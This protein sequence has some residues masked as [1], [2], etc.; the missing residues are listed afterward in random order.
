MKCA[1]EEQDSGQLQLA[2][3]PSRHGAAFASDLQTLPTQPKIAARRVTGESQDWRLSCAPEPQPVMGSAMNI[4]TCG[5]FQW[6][7]VSQDPHLQNY[8]LGAYVVKATPRLP[9]KR[10]Q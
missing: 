10:W 3:L 5:K 2:L 9:Y 1:R 7:E 8:L 4:C 6:N